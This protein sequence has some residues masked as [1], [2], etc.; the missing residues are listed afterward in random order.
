MRNFPLVTEEK[1]ELE[2][3]KDAEGEEKEEGWEEEFND[4]ASNAE[5]IDPDIVVT[6]PKTKD[7]APRQIK[8]IKMVALKSA[9]TSDSAPIVNK[10]LNGKQLE[11]LKPEELDVVF[12][13]A[14]KMIAKVRDSKVQKSTV[15]AKSYFKGISSEIGEINKA[16]KNFWKK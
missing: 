1:E 4:V 7:A 15:D 6:P 5:I 14:S 8:R 12:H 11:A 13:T 10:L 3:A 16:N 2:E 9:M